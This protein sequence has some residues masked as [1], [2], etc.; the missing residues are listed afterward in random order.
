MIARAGQFYPLV[1]R[2]RKLVFRAQWGYLRELH[3][4][5][6]G[7]SHTPAYVA[8]RMGWHPPAWAVEAMAYGVCLERLAEFTREARAPSLTGHR[9]RT[10]LKY[11]RRLVAELATHRERMRARGW[12][13]P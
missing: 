12:R 7:A 8:R 1:P 11:A 5:G 3:H 13:L 2:G 9:R 10:A 4:K 6:L